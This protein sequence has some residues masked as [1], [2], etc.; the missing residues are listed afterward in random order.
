MKNAIMY[1]YQFIPASLRQKEK[2]YFFSI[3]RKNYLLTLYKRSPEEADNLYK[4]SETLKNYNTPYSKIILNKDKNMISIINNH[5][6]VLLE[7]SSYLPP[8]NIE[9]IINQEIVLPNYSLF[10]KLFRTG[11]K[12]LWEAKIDYFEYQIT[13]FGKKYQLLS[14]SIPYYI[15]LAENA[16]SYFDAVQ[17]TS[18]DYRDVLVLCHKRLN[19]DDALAFYNPLNL[20]IDHKS[21]EIGEYLKEVFI[22]DTYDISS[23]N[24]LISSI[25]LS[26]YGFGLLMARLL[27]P[28]FYFDQYE[29]IINENQDEKN[30]NQFIIRVEEY[31]RYLYDIYNLIRKRAEIPPLDWLNRIFKA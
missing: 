7:N 12:T 6:Y 26:N 24:K 28:C 15:G 8:F 2:D 3:G 21:R 16:I 19:T 31:E 11:W 20:V 1:Y 4:L 18:K 9:E 17:A 22:K 5:P 14:E 10:P 27:F 25:Q 13:T 30:I 29:R 23:I